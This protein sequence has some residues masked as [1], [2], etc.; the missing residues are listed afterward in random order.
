MHDAMSRV[1]VVDDEPQVREVLVELLA[2]MG[3]DV[4][5]AENGA[6][7][8]TAVAR[9]RPDAVCLDLWM[10]GM[11]GLEV[12]DHLIR[13]HPGLPV[14]IVTADPFTDTMEDARA[15]GAFDYIRK[16]FDVPQLQRVLES[17]L[18]RASVPR[19]GRTDTP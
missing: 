6:A 18:A 9:S 2:D 1:L 5:Q 7:A 8:L 3:H 16:P 12:L 4:T 15:R 10:D 17:A 13:E 11:S 14:V 19:P